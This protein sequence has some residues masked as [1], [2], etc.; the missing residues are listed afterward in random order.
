MPKV[1]KSE[2][3]PVLFSRTHFNRV[4][5]NTLLVLAISL[6]TL[7]SF[8]NSL[9]DLLNPGNRSGDDG[10]GIGGTGRIMLPGGLGGTGLRP[11]LGAIQTT[12][13]SGTALTTP[14]QEP[15]INDVATLEVIV[16][17]E[18]RDSGTQAFQPANASQAHISNKITR[19]STASEGAVNHYS[20][21]SI[22]P[23]VEGL[24]IASSNAFESSMSQSISI[25][26]YIAQN[27]EDSNSLLAQ[28]AASQLNTDDTELNWSDVADWLL[29]NEIKREAV[30]EQALARDE[31]QLMKPDLA[32][33]NA[34]RRPQ[35]PPVQR[36]RP[37]QRAQILPPRIR[38]LKL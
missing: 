16:T 3:E 33:S 23:Q 15:E 10:S 9:G 35:L 13:K 18:A 7:L 20:E 26:Q 37:I 2:Q 30:S 25:D 32:Q 19:I 12:P 6:L 14:Q 22:P 27:T 36:A 4:L 38:P 21:A 29:A 24:A 5:R 17:H 1:Y 11:F 8:Q 34:L 28:T 31:P